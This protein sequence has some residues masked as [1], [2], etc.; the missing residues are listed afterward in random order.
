MAGLEGGSDSTADTT[1]LTM[2]WTGS[3]AKV[4]LH[5]VN[6]QVRCKSVDIEFE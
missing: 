2:T 5:A 6:G 4:V 3:A 1:S